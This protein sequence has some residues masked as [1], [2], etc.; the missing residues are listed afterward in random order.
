MNNLDE[1]IRKKLEKQ[2]DDSHNIVCQ[3]IDA[4]LTLTPIKKR[5]LKKCSYK[6]CKHEILVEH[7]RLLDLHMMIA[8]DLESRELQKM[9]IDVCKCRKG[10]TYCFCVTR[11]NKWLK[12]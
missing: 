8:N 9:P 1:L 6:L 4:D 12:I 11:K 3:N 10:N 2:I 5:Y 7:N